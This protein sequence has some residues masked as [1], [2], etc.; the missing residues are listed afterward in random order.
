MRSNTKDKL[1]LIAALGALS[2]HGNATPF[3]RVA[4][5]HNAFARG[6][7]S[8]LGYHEVLAALGFYEHRG[9]GGGH[10]AR[11][12]R[13]KVQA[14]LRNQRNTKTPHQ[15]NQEIARRAARLGVLNG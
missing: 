1:G 5:Y 13:M 14:K 3:S 12:S 9:K 4:S 6:V 8:G 7:Q 10:R 2:I 11:G 15:G